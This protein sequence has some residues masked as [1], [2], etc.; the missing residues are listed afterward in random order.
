MPNWTKNIVVIA[1]EPAELSRFR[2]ECTSVIIPNKIAPPSKDEG[3]EYIDFER[4]VPYPEGFN[5][6]A[7][8]PAPMEVRA[9]ARAAAGM[10]G[11]A[12]FRYDWIP[13]EAK[14]SPDPRLLVA[15]LHT[16]R[17]PLTD[18]E[19]ATAVKE[20]EEMASVYEKN[21]EVAPDCP[22]WFEFNHEH[23]GTK[24][25]ACSPKPP[26]IGGGGR[27][28][29]YEF[30]TAWDAPRKIY[31]VLNERYPNLKFAIVVQHED[32][33]R[34]ERIQEDIEDVYVNIIL[35]VEMPA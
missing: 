27:Y 3:T 8:S 5:P 19:I 1:G 22:T 17:W 32:G 24:W 30:E 6:H 15:F 12:D 29:K 16:R 10:I 35:D 34:I 9:I 13:Q 4:I 11:D 7:V 28:I 33:Q 21:L 18:D 25:N 31:E 2:E 20:S 23:W 26:T 14:D